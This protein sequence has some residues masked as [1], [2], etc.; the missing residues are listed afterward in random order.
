MSRSKHSTNTPWEKKYSYSRGVRVG[1]V[2]HI[3]GTLANLN[4]CPDPSSAYDQA[5][6]AL[7]IIEMALKQLGASKTHVVR[8][9]MYVINIARDSDEIGRAHGDMFRGVD[10]VATMVEVRKLIGED[11][12]VEIEAEAIIE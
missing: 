9:R 10:P 12:L 2:V 6:S 7:R 8:T 11:Y 3:A 1:N 4:D 5:A